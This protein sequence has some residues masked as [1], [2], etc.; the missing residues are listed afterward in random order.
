[1]NVEDAVKG[2]KAITNNSG[3]HGVFRDCRVA[4][5]DTLELVYSN[6]EDNSCCEIC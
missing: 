5:F 1:M 2:E 6:N 4:V 3:Y